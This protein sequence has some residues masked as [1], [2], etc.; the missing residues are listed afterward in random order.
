MGL[1]KNLEFHL[2]AKVPFRSLESVRN[3]YIY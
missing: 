2:Q 1:K 3:E